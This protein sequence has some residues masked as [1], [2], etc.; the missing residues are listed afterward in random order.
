MLILLYFSEKSLSFFSLIAYMSSH[1]PLTVPEVTETY[2]MPG[3]K[4][5]RVNQSVSFLHL[6]E[7]IKTGPSVKRLFSR[8]GHKW[9]NV[10]S[11][12]IHTSLLLLIDFIVSSL[13]VFFL[14]LIKSF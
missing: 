9:V 4:T 8:H 10:L 6:T 12:S 2:A 5:Q 7:T 3:R 13:S 11:G 1:N 14:H